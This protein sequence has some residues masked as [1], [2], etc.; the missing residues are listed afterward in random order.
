MLKAI[1]PG[2]RYILCNLDE[3]YAKDIYEVIKRGQMA[4]GA[5]AWPEGD[6]SFEEWIRL[7][8]PEAVEGGA[9]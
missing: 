8:W 6:I 1:K 4:N 5:E 9:E 3:P 2:R 7:T